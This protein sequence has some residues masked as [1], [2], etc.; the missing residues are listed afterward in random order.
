M[1]SLQKTVLI[2]TTI[3]LIMIQKTISKMEDFVL[4]VND[5]LSENLMPTSFFV[6]DSEN[7]LNHLKLNEKSESIFNASQFKDHGTFSEAFSTMGFHR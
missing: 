6:I 3:N 4:D 7:S 5:I 2:I 1:N